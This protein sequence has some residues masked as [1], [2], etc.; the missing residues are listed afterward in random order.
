[1]LSLGLGA[2]GSLIARGLCPLTWGAQ[3]LMALLDPADI[4]S[5]FRT[6]MIDP[7][8]IARDTLFFRRPFGDIEG[9]PIHRPGVWYD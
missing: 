3:H 1:V 6:P 5:G 2:V 9:V 7:N 4:V 8:S